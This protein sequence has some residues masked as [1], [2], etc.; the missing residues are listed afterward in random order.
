MAKEIFVAKPDEL[1]EGQKR[2]V[3]NGGSEIG[4]YRWKGRLFAY[5]NLCGHQG[6]PACEG[7]TIAKVEDVIAE[8]RTHQG[9][10]FNEDD[11]HIVCPWHGWEYHLETGV[12]AADPTFRLRKYDVVEREDGIYVLA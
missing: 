1:S 9:M 3:P 12:H 6:G 11:M 10:R 4:V 8:D 2:I 5:Q 7:V